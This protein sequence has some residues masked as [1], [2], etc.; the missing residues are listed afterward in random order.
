MAKQSL[1]TNRVYV[2]VEKRANVF[3]N[4]GGGGFTM[5]WKQAAEVHAKLGQELASKMW[6]YG[7][8]ATQ[9]EPPTGG[10]PVLMRQAA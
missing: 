5:T 4:V 1:P 10:T 7:G 8:P 6:E 2:D 3:F 9:D